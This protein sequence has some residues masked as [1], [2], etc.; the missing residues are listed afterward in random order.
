MTGIRYQDEILHPTVRPYTGTIGPKP[1]PHGLT[2]MSISFCDCD[3]NYF[4]FFMG[5]KVVFHRQGD[6]T[7][8]E[9]GERTRAT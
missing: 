3:P 9:V 5:F 2:M 8:G 1:H 7:T 6:F 4:L